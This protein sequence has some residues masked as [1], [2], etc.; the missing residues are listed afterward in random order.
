[1]ATSELVDVKSEET[2]EP[3]SFLWIDHIHTESLLQPVAGCLI[4]LSLTIAIGISGPN[5]ITF[6]RTEKSLDY[7]STQEFSFQAPP[8]SPYNRFL[9]YELSFQRRS[10]RSVPITFS[11]RVD[12]ITHTAR[13]NRTAHHIASV[14][15][16][17]INSTSTEAVPLFRDRLL[18]YQDAQLFLTIS[19]PDESYR[20]LTMS[21]AVGTHDHTSFEAYFRLLYSAVEVCAFFALIRRVMI[22]RDPIPFE[23]KGTAAL[24]LF[25]VCSNNPAY[26]LHVYRPHSFY[27]FLELFATPLLHSSVMAICLFL[28]ES[29]RLVSSAP[30]GFGL[31]FGI[32]NF[33]AEF[34][35]MG[36]G[37]GQTF[38]AAQTFV[39]PIPK[40]V[41]KIRA[42]ILCAFIVLTMSKVVAIL[43]RWDIAEGSKFLMY[44]VAASFAIMQ[45]VVGAFGSLT[46]LMRGSETEWILTFAF[47]NL[48]VLMVTYLHWTYEPGRRSYVV[49]ACA[50]LGS[51]EIALAEPDVDRQGDL[52]LVGDDEEKSD[53]LG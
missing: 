49:S 40:R 38:S 25:A 31:I 21:V 30:G 51:D 13:I 53:E 43:G 23:Q 47:S 7:V 35:T 11:Y 14:S 1:M 5:P 24:L 18:T 16:A 50:Q 29:L 22:S 19:S 42:I 2:Q 3:E 26:I 12:V 4:L 10:S 48:F 52:F 17:N 8:I 32:V 28:L 37:L 45:G 41:N 33:C 46:N 34:L 27:V 20:G 39:D 36:Y 6:L 9:A 15:I 44:F